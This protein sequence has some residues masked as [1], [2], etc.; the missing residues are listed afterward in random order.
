MGYLW[1]R[2][3]WKIKIEQKSERADV[4]RGHIERAGY[5]SQGKAQDKGR[6]Q[7]RSPLRC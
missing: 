4:H 2:Y 7:H 5:G 3:Q 1:H 6:Q